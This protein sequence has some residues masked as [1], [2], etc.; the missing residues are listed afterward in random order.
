VA[1]AARTLAPAACA[2]LA[3][4]CGAP[5]P[6]LLLLSLD[7]L[8][9]DAVG[10]YAPDGDSSTPNLDAFAARA[11]RF[12]RAFVPL[13]FTLPSH[14]SLFTGVHPDVHGVW[15]RR[16][17]LSP[18]LRTL[19]ERLHEAGYATLGIATNA[20]MKQEYGFGRGFD[21]YERLE[22]GAF[23]AERVNR[24]ALELLDRRGGDARP[25][26]LFL[27]YLDPHSDWRILP[28]DSP[29]RFR[30]D[31]ELAGAERE[32]CA[33]E[34]GACAT[35]FLLRA[36]RARLELPAE[37]LGK[38]EALYGRGV[39]YLDEELGRL[40]AALEARGFL[41]SA[42]VVVSSDHGEEF[43]EHGRFGHA[44]TYD[45]TIAVPLLIRF[46]KDR[47][48]GRVVEEMVETVDLLPTLADYLGLPPPEPAQGESLLPLLE[49]G[50][51]PEGHAL[52]RDKDVRTRYALRTATHKLIY[53]PATSSAELYDLSSD[54]GETRNR[55]GE[56]PARVEALGRRLEALVRANAELARGFPALETAESVLSPEEERELQE[57]GYLE[58]PAPGAAGAGGGGAR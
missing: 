37:L 14:M 57:I 4:A 44:Q 26:F 42:L 1:R 7:T 2:A 55:A 40:F 28:Y 47:H 27:H 25:V 34:A 3:A 50:G 21:H 51:R 10:V 33:P 31:L 53:D 20:W 16:A 13:P 45:E 49:G 38:L 35:R 23:Y 52:S 18:R 29:P 22:P 58:E 6:D 32:F 8:R 12:D 11:V 39:R 54:P 9:R 17:R 46:P 30:A 41:D 36:D 48:A 43:R 56:D 15:H 24:R 19:P 5:R